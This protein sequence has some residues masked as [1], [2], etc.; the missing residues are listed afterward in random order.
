MSSSQTLP[1]GCPL[2][3]SYKI[4]NLKSRQWNQ[5]PDRTN[6]IILQQIKETKW[7]AWKAQLDGSWIEKYRYLEREGS[8]SV[9][10][11][12]KISPTLGKPISFPHPHLT[13]KSPPDLP[14]HMPRYSPQGEGPRTLLCIN[15]CSKNHR[16][17]ATMFASPAEWNLRDPSYKSV[18]LKWILLIP[19]GVWGAI[20]D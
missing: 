8:S 16:L 7:R 5:K 13:P 17:W 3:S 12:R 10:G 11:N 6:T 15:N 20:L 19:L 18:F 9:S 14:Q 1:I 2:S 4:M